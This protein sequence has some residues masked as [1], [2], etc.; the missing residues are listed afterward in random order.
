MGDHVLVAN[1]EAGDPESMAHCYVATIIY[2]YE[3]SKWI[4]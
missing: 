3:M 2:M 4:V 1:A